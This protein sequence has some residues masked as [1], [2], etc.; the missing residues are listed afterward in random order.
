M[1]KGKYTKQWLTVWLPE[2][3]R[4]C[5]TS[6]FWYYCRWSPWMSHLTSQ[7]LS[8]PF[9]K[10]SMGVLWG[11]NQIMHIKCLA[12]VYHLARRK[13]SI[14]PSY[15]LSVIILCNTLTLIL[16]HLSLHL[17]VPERKICPITND[18]LFP[19]N[20]VTKSVVCLIIDGMTEE[21]NTVGISRFNTYAFLVLLLHLLRFISCY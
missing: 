17:N 14:R 9:C 4:I 11:L 10:T 20:A 16:R 2:S 15:Y 18:F 13:H 7:S 1:I 5:F 8:F 6:W 19:W 12:Q 3:D 21:R